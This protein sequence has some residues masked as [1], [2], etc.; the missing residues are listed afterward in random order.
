VGGTR[1]GAGGRNR[2]CPHD[3]GVHRAKEAL[4]FRTVTSI[5]LSL[6][7]GH[8][9]V[10]SEALIA[11]MSALPRGKEAGSPYLSGP[12]LVDRTSTQ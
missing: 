7:R 6:A 4:H 8:L 3:K 9:P 1:L 2:R 11:A 12:L 5:G 10:P